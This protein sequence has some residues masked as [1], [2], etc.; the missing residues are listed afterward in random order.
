VGADQPI[1]EA[2][3]DFAWPSTGPDVGCNQL[4][5]DGCGD[6]VRSEPGFGLRRELSAEETALLYDAARWRKHN[7]LV[8][9]ARSSRLYVCRCGGHHAVKQP[10]GLDDPYHD[11]FRHPPPR[12]WHCGGHPR[13]ALPF[14]LD[15]ER[16]AAE[17]VDWQALIEGAV[18]HERAQDRPDFTRAYAACWWQRL[19]HLLEHLP[20]SEDVARAVQR[21]LEA[22]GEPVFQAAAVDFF[23]RL[24]LAPGGDA[25]APLALREG[26]GLMSQP[27]P[28]RPHQSVGELLQ[29]A[30]AERLGSR[31]QESSSDQLEATC[32]ASHRAVMWPSSAAATLLEAVTERDPGWVRAHLDAIWQANPATITIRAMLRGF[33]RALESRELASTIR[34]IEAADWLDR[35]RLE[36]LTRQVLPPDLA[37]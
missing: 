33:S 20:Q 21:G 7:K 29:L 16:L 36:R 4:I 12:G 30:L 18:R 27:N 23:R 28:E 6:P 9:Q 17:G 1:P 15:G 5:C 11:D 3:Y 14:D 8:R 2:P 31:D 34:E 35:S 37:G 13:L 25:L 26:Q 32:A 10:R 22:D 19:Y 24:P